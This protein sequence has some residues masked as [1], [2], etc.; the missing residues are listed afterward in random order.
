MDMTQFSKFGDKLYMLIISHLYLVGFILAGF[1]VISGTLYGIKHR[2]GDRKYSRHLPP[3]VSNS[4]KSEESIENVDFSQYP[5]TRRAFLDKIE[6]NW[7]TEHLIKKLMPQHPLEL[8]LQEHPNLLP[9]N[10]VQQTHQ[11]HRAS[12]SFS[13]PLETTIEQEYEKTRQGQLL[14]IGE[15]GSGKTTLFLRLAQHLIAQAKEDETRPIPVILKLSSWTK[16]YPSFADWLVMEILLQ[17][18]DST[19]PLNFA[20]A[21][22]REGRLLLLLDGLDEVGI[23]NREDCVEAINNYLY[24]QLNNR[25]TAVPLVVTCRS[26]VYSSFDHRLKVQRV[27]EILPPSYEEVEDYFLSTAPD[28]WNTVRNDDQLKKLVQQPLMLSIITKAYS[29]SDP[30]QV[31][32]GKSK[33]EALRIIWNKYIDE[34]LYNNKKEISHRWKE[35]QIR[36]W[37][38]MLAVQMQQQDKPTTFRIENLQKDWLPK[39]LQ[40]FFPICMSVIIGIIVGIIVGTLFSITMGVILS[41]LFGV[42]TG[43]LVN[44][45]K[46]VPTERLGWKWKKFGKCILA[47]IVCGIILGILGSVLVG[48]GLSSILGGVL[49][50]VVFGV[51]NGIDKGQSTDQKRLR[52]NAGIWQS[53]ISGLLVGLFSGVVIALIV[54]TLGGVVFGIFSGMVFGLLSGTEKTFREDGGIIKP[55]TNFTQVIVA[56]IIGTLFGVLGVLVGWL[57]FGMIVVTKGVIGAIFD[58]VLFGI[59]FSVLDGGDAFLLHYSLRLFLR[60]INLLPLRLVDFLEEMAEHTLLIHNGR[61]Y[62]FFHPLLQEHLVQEY[63]VKENARFIERSNTTAS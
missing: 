39:H 19:V 51:I 40:P 11:E 49:G 58:G 16:Q 31:P 9:P 61:D 17:Y 36:R 43:V 42:L 5:S 13:L 41:I 56:I 10:S 28:L 52:P 48:G 54:G 30:S 1:L 15:P 25:K 60:F 4:E 24:T 21:L 6:N 45:R 12:S 29:S 3:A 50:G 53:G 7:I 8:G 14:I 34:M 44:N 47:G 46:I 18:E 59:Y 20:K 33:E 57:F 22:V 62:S 63:L 35:Q 37:L 2:K 27:I 38:I 55:Q 32:T 23:E 26:N